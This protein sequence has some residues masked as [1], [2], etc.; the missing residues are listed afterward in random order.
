MLVNCEESK[1]LTTALENPTFVRGLFNGHCVIFYRCK[2][3]M[4]AEIAVA[5]QN[6]GKRVLGIGDGFND[7]V[8]LRTADVGIDILGKKAQKSFFSCDFGIPT[9]RSFDRLT[10]VHGHMSLHRSV[11][12]VNS[13][14]Y[15]VVLFAACQIVYQT[16]TDYMGHSFFDNSWLTIFRVFHFEVSISAPRLDLGSK[17]QQILTLTRVRSIWDFQPLDAKQE[18]CRSIFL[19]H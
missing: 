4:K 16:W 10:L 6:L 17:S 18:P 9:F 14:F 3:T 12:A 15:Q 5:L 1:V 2:P 13:S 8:L 7:S 19:T 11:L